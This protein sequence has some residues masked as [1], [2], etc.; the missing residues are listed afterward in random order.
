M[1]GQLKSGKRVFF[2]KRGQEENQKKIKDV[3]FFK[4]FW[5]NIFAKK[6]KSKRLKKKFWWLEKFF[7]FFKT[8]RD[9][10]KKGSGQNLLFFF[11]KTISVMKKGTKDFSTK[12]KKKLLFSQ[13]RFQKQS[14][15]RK[16][17]KERSAV[18]HCNVL[19][20]CVRRCSA[21][22]WKRLPRARR[23][24]AS[25]HEVCLTHSVLF[26]CHSPMVVRSLT[27]RSLE[28]FGAIFSGVAI[29]KFHPCS[30][31]VPE[32]TVLIFAP[33]IPSTCEGVRLL[34][35]TRRLRRWSSPQ[36]TSARV[37]VHMW[38]FG[39]SSAIMHNE[40]GPERGLP[41]TAVAEGRWKLFSLI[42]EGLT[43]RDAVA[44]MLREQRVRRPG[45]LFSVR[46]SCLHVPSFPVSFVA[47]TDQSPSSSSSTKI[48]T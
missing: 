32:G 6:K 18:A 10:H 9:Y 21:Q 29:L 7:F 33:W 30:S 15:F 12:F 13:R 35:S 3:S 39:T 11:A 2:Q 37:F 28:N 5:E 1:K 43:R 27:R 20:S 34:R 16:M 24:A 17:M 4:I 31:R 19:R 25:T 8:R 46:T 40:V 42:E 26:R 48:S 14:L 45:C 22:E 47:V 23:A 44:S 38:E 36:R 41:H